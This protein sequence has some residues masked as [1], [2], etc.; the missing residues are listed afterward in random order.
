M[1]FSQI[2]SAVGGVLVLIYLIWQVIIKFLGE[3]EWFTKHKKEKIAKEEAI[4]LDLLQKN[5]KEVLAPMLQDIKDHNK[6]Q[7]RK[8]ICLMH[9][10]NDIMRVE[11]I[12]IYY[13]YLPYKKM[14]QYSRELLNKLF[15]DY[16]DQD[17][18]SFIEDMYNEM[19]TWPVVSTEEDLKR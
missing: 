18:D 16:Q 17:G 13:R 3:K 19:K 11:I 9:S 2:A 10:S 1:N 8:I 15:Y 12:K 14:L 4:R 7:D 5:I 6:E